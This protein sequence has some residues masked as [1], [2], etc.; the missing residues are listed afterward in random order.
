VNIRKRHLTL[1]AVFAVIF[2]AGFTSAVHMRGVFSDIG[3]VIL[4]VFN[5]NLKNKNQFNIIACNDAVKKFI[6]LYKNNGRNFFKKA[7]SLSTRYI[8]H[9]QNIFEKYKIPKEIAYLALIESGFNS[10]ATSRAYA[11]GMWQFMYTTGLGY[12]LKINYWVD[13][14]RDFTRATHAA[15]KYLSDLYLT[16]KD[17]HLALAAYNSGAGYIKMQLHYNKV[18]DFWALY[19]KGKLYQ[20]TMEYVPRFIAA[21]IIARNPEQ[22]GFHNIEYKKPHIFKKVKEKSGA[23]IYAISKKYNMSINHF[24][25]LNPQIK[26]W[27]IPSSRGGYYINVS[28]T[29]ISAN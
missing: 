29:S 15:A 25:K 19:N 7:L 5:V 17:W 10:K 23:N 21:V 24:K 4:G 16:F 27:K 11:H 8:P 18:K 9:I 28:D 22:F 26:R 14:R 6:K 3:K 12:G 13:E 2:I 1:I 20:E